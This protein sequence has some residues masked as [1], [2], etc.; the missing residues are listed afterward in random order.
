MVC[1]LELRNATAAIHSLVNIPIYFLFAD[2]C[3]LSAQCG[4][5]V[6]DGS[7]PYCKAEA[8]GWVGGAIKFALKRAGGLGGTTSGLIICSW[9]A[10]G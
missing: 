7:C 2:G 6:D 3:V 9:G 8:V 10:D 5:R 1:L 4:L